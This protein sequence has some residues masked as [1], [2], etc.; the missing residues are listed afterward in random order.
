MGIMT[1]S[2]IHGSFADSRV[3]VLSPQPSS[4]CRPG[5]Y[6]AFAA[7]NRRYRSA[8]GSAAAPT[9]MLLRST[10]ILGAVLV[11]GSASASIAAG[12]KTQRAR[13]ELHASAHAGEV[14]GSA[15]RVRCGGNAKRQ[16]L[17]DRGAALVQPGQWGQK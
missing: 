3:R 9:T 13:E 17:H 7:V 10:L 6:Q 14:H 12:A 15:H 8:T 2:Q 11:A 16:T 1:I 4:S 5:R